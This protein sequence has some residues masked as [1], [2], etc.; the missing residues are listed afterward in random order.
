VIV[1]IGSEFDPCHL[2]TK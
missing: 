2:W 1:C